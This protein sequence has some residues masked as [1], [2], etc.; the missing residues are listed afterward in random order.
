MKIITYTLA[1]S[2]NG[3]NIP[4]S[5]QST[6]MRDYCRKKNISYV[7]P[8]TEICYKDNYYILNKLILNNSQEDILLIMT[9]ILML[10]INNEELLKSILIK[11]SKI[12]WHFP[13]EGKILDNDSLINWITNFNH[14]NKYKK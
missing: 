4:I 14:L 13:L 5:I 2:F 7:L 8:Q 1:R 10:P 3:L 11:N 6:Y 9:S 12:I